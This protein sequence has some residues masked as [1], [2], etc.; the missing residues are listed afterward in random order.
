M[1]RK[2]RGSRNVLGVANEQ[3]C[4]N[5]ERADQGAAGRRGGHVS[6]SVFGG[7]GRIEEKDGGRIEG[8]FVASDVE[9]NVTGFES[10][11]D[12]NKIM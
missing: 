7:D 2:L 1:K 9:L 4:P 8:V 5:S 6:A 12:I 3:S 11:Y 10:D